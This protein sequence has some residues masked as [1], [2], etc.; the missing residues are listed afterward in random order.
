MH[1]HETL[2]DGI[3]V[4]ELEGEV[5]GHFAPV[6]RSLLKAKAKAACPALV[7]DLSRL[8]FIDSTGIAALV[9]YVRDAVSFGGALCLVGLTE[10]VRSIFTIARLERAFP[11]F[12]HRVEATAALH[13]GRVPL[14]GTALFH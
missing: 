4:L 2:Q 3:P 10:P 7:L 1:L 12:D 9:E 11:I 13:A 5:D 6:L 14:A 8:S